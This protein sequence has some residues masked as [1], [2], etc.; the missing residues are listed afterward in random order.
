MSQDASPGI[1]KELTSPRE[2]AQSASVPRTGSPG[3][4][5]AVPAGLFVALVA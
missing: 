3:T 2:D 1:A 4:F 5:S